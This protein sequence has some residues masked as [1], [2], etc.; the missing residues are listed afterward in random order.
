MLKQFIEC[1][2]ELCIFCGKYTAE[3]EGACD[4]CKWYPIKNG[5]YHR[6]TPERQAMID[7]AEDIRFGCNWCS[8]EDI[9][10]EVIYRCPFLKDDKCAIGDPTTWDI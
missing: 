9:S 7:L 4:G 8:C 2:N 6:I 1:I 5:S 3:H 10:N